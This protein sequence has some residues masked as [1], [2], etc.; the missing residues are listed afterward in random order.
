MTKKTRILNSLESIGIL[1]DRITDDESYEVTMPFIRFTL[2]DKVRRLVKDL[3]FAKDIL[4]LLDCTIAYSDD[5][6]AFSYAFE[7]LY[8][9]VI[10]L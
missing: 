4:E 7:D 1:F 10:C 6:N 8:N 9:A 5:A 2:D 3:P